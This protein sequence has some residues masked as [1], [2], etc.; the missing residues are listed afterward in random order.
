M[1]FRDATGIGLAAAVMLSL[2]MGSGYAATPE[3]VLLTMNGDP[4]SQMAVTWRTDKGT[5]GAAQI[6]E[7]KPGPNLEADA[8]TIPATVAEAVETTPGVTHYYKS[9]T[10]AGL[11]P[12]TK[13]AYRVGDG[14]VWSEWNHF[15]TASDKPEPFSFLYVGDAQ[16]DVLSMWSRVIRDAFREGS[17]AR[18]IL[19]AGDL[20]NHAN[21]D[22]NW[23]E[24]FEAAGWIN[25]VIPSVAVPG[26]HEHYKPKDAHG[27]IL[28][29]LWRPQFEYPRNGLKGL[30][31]TNYF[32]DYQ[33]VRIVGMNSSVDHDE[34][35][36]WLDSI[37]ADNPNR[38][39]ILTFHHP[40]FSAAAKRD[41]PELREAWLPIID[42]YNVDLIL[43]GHDHTY[44]RSQ[45]LSSGTMVGKSVGGSVYVVSISGPKMYNLTETNDDIMARM[46]EDTQLYQMITIDGNTLKYIAR[47]AAGDLYDA[48]D[49]IKGS[50]GKNELV[51]KIPEGNLRRRPHHHHHG[52]HEH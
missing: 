25:R 45:K 16:N 46:A 38:W 37:L 42:K 29:R 24:W 50:D 30:E 34:Q 17:K 35:A 12:S 9:V 8:R 5:T 49:L 14:E 2:F 10:M 48:F 3:R 20:I 21:N 19:H 13:Y 26:N 4:A 18:F 51:N 1:K 39:T 11:Q 7:A 52:E 22:E 40:V 28:S 47:T 23:G 32:L 31:D 36:E 15:E 43:Q 44:G 33:G 41:N 27:R 6:T